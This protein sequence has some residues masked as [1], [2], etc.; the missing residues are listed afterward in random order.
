MAIIA[1]MEKELSGGSV[2]EVV[3]GVIATPEWDILPQG[4]LYVLW[5]YLSNTWAI[6]IGSLG[7]YSFGK[8]V[9]AYIGSGAKRLSH[10]LRRHWTGARNLRWH[11]DWLRA[12]ATPVGIDI[13]PNSPPGPIGNELP[14]HQKF[15][16]RQGT[17]H[18]SPVPSEC[19]LAGSLSAAPGVVRFIPRFGASDC[20]C[21]G[22]LFSI[23]QDSMAYFLPRSWDKRLLCC[24]RELP[25][26]QVF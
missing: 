11:I 19:D 22:H 17:E 12:V 15:P 2:A 16:I 13:L 9:Y 20:R 10:R 14:T 23:P 3:P 25:T 7:E 18:F 8:G 1:P 26:Q 24:Y 5:L 4:G 21:A 6:R